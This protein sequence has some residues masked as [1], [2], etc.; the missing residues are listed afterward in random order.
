MLLSLLLIAG[1]YVS[2]KLN[3]ISISG[4]SENN[5]NVV[6]AQF[7]NQKDKNNDEITNLAEKHNY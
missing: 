7:Q 4:I 1:I 2:A 5:Q 3:L 6:F